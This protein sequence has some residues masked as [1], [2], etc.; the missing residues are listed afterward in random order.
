M[1]W[2]HPEEGLLA[3]GRFL[4]VAEQHGRLISADRRLGAAAR[5]RGRRA[6]AGG[7]LR[8]SVNV[9]ARELGEP[10]FAERVER[11][12]RPTAGVAPERISLEITETT[13]MEGGEASI[14]GLEAARGARPAALPR[15]LRHRLLARSRGSRGCR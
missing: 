8:V 5:L 7:R 1:R 14:A 3:P 12:A 2:Q 11:H 13:L 6:L 9:S 4:P 15:R 10:G